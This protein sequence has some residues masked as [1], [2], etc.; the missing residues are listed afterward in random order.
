M[1]GNPGLRKC[2]A[3]IGQISMGCYSQPQ[4]ASPGQPWLHGQPSWGS[5]LWSAQ[6]RG[7]L[8]GPVLIVGC[9]LFINSSG[10]RSM[11]SFPL[12]GPQMPMSIWSESEHNLKVFLFTLQADHPKLISHTKEGSADTCHDINEPRKHYA[13]WKKP[14]TG[15]Q[16]QYDSIYMRFLD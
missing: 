11:R 4:T 14:V 5:L 12:W 13:R 6:A 3:Q 8:C 9:W 15:G 16:I 7:H 1:R 10:P 2:P